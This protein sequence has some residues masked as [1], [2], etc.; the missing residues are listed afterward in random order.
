MYSSAVHLGNSFSGSEMLYNWATPVIHNA[1]PY[2]QAGSGTYYISQ[3]SPPQRAIVGDQPAQINAETSLMQAYY[4]SQAQPPPPGYTVLSP[5]HAAANGGGG[6]TLV[7]WSGGMPQYWAGGLDSNQ[8]APAKGGSICVLPPGVY[9]MVGGP[10]AGGEGA[11]TAERGVQWLPLSYFYPQERG[12]GQQTPQPPVSEGDSGK[13][14]VAG[15]SSSDQGNH[16]GS[17]GFNTTWGPSSSS[18]PSHYPQA[19]GGGSSS[20]HSPALHT[21]HD[22]VRVVLPPQGMNCQ[23]NGSFPFH[24][25]QRA[26]PQSLPALL[27]PTSNL[28]VPQ[29]T[30]AGA[31]SMTRKGKP[32][33]KRNA[34]P[35]DV[36]FQT[37]PSTPPLPPTFAAATAPPPSSHSESP[38]LS[39]R[40][41]SGATK[42]PEAEPLMPP[43]QPEAAAAVAE[44]LPTTAAGEAVSSTTAAAAPLPS[45]MNGVEYTVGG[46]YEGKIKRYNPQRGFGFITG[47]YQLLFDQ[48][49]CEEICTQHLTPQLMAQSQGSIAEVSEAQ[50]ES[51]NGS[52]GSWDGVKTEQ[53]P[54]SAQLPPEGSTVPNNVVVLST[55]QWFLRMAEQESHGPQLPPLFSASS[56]NDHQSVPHSS[57]ASKDGPG[58][59]SPNAGEDAAKKLAEGV[60]IEPSSVSSS[61]RSTPLPFP[62]K[63]VKKPMNHLGDIFVHHSCISMSGLDLLTPFTV[64]RFS[65]AVVMKTV[66]AVDVIPIGPGWCTLQD[67]ALKR[68][69]FRSPLSSSRMTPLLPST[70]HG[71]PSTKLAPHYNSLGVSNVTPTTT[72]TSGSTSPPPTN[73]L[74]SL[75]LTLQGNHLLIPKCTAS[76]AALEVL[77]QRW[78]AKRKRSEKHRGDGV[79]ASSNEGGAQGQPAGDSAERKD[80]SYFFVTYSGQ[81][82]D[83]SETGQSI[84]STNDDQEQKWSADGPREHTAVVEECRFE[85]VVV[86]PSAAI[87]NAI[88]GCSELVVIRRS[89]QALGT[90]KLSMLLDE[91]FKI[92]QTNVRAPERVNATVLALSQERACAAA[93]ERSEASPVTERTGFTS[94][95]KEDESGKGTGDKSSGVPSG[96]SGS[97]KRPGDPMTSSSAC[98]PSSND[99]KSDKERK[100]VQGGSG[101]RGSGEGTSE[102]HPTDTSPLRLH[103]DPAVVVGGREANPPQGSPRREEQKAAGVKSAGASPESPAKPTRALEVCWTSATKKESAPGVLHSNSGTPL[104]RPSSDA[105]NDAGHKAAAVKTKPSER[106]SLGEERACG[107][108]DHPHGSSDEMFYSEEQCTSTTTASTLPESRVQNPIANSDW[109]EMFNQKISQEKIKDVLLHKTDM[110]CFTHSTPK[111]GSGE[112]NAPAPAGRVPPDSSPRPHLLSVSRRRAGGNG[113]AAGSGGAAAAAGASPAPRSGNVG[114]PKELRRRTTESVTSDSSDSNAKRESRKRPGPGQDEKVF[115][116]G[117]GMSGREIDSDIVSGG[118]PDGYVQLDL[119]KVRDLPRDLRQQLP[120][121]LF[122]IALPSGVTR[123]L[124]IPTIPTEGGKPLLVPL[125]VTSPS[126]SSDPSGQLSVEPLGDN[127]LGPMKQSEVFSSHS[128]IGSQLS[129][130]AKTPPVNLTCTPTKIESGGG[131]RNNGMGGYGKEE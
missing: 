28:A 109:T 99:N 40:A 95:S 75:S 49:Q 31:G 70:H 103:V 37:P 63:F 5:T 111:P 115:M 97:Q 123:T 118:S 58:G 122:V 126:G 106:S 26:L 7:A 20:F 64:V 59:G 43:I 102:S 117:L 1:P 116:D 89:S 113:A 53:L 19:G 62:I 50:E 17:A 69:T 33:L 73:L 42:K 4:S 14:G 15:P 72:A 79:N 86:I 100:A 85:D 76:R 21:S 105:M 78:Q 83:S 11:E 112:E 23:P 48:D 36:A 130:E 6:P 124:N 54:T 90:C 16:W 65:V 18:Q 45:C 87:P 30:I 108:H 55:M 60:V 46:W 3:P 82:S 8:A 13:G 56:R 96:T 127:G 51:G 88:E 52:S 107:S 38:L 104:S 77:T 98:H 84:A 125:D 121:G 2:A 110:R 81:Q 129:F 92:H 44:A 39:T 41:P 128:S 61:H 74:Q 57:L 35:S 80:K 71:T 68:A 66:Q 94:E 119:V 9:P 25:A 27:H 67:I 114:K 131:L 47:L 93:K 10:P 12:P 120:A 22:G 101:D 91:Y 24:H 29:V 34:T 32:Q